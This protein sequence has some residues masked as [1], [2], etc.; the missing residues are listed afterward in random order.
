[1]DIIE[2]Q[3]SNLVKT[4]FPAFYQESGPLFIQFVTE[5]YKWMESATPARNEY[6]C[7]QKSM[8]AVKAKSANV[9]G[10]GTFFANQYSSG[11][12]I[13]ICKGEN[14]ND[15]EIFTV[16]R[17]SNNT[18]LTLKS[19]KLPTFSIPKTRHGTVSDKPNALYYARQF[20]EIKDIDE[21]LEEFIV[22]FKTKYLVGIQFDTKTDTRKFVKHSLDLYRSKGTERSIDLLFK[23]VFGKPA[24]VYYP[25]QD[26]FRL[27]SGEWYIP[28]Y[29]ELSLNEENINLKN[30]QIKG[31]TS[32]AT[33][34]VEEVVRRLVGDKFVDIA[35]ISAINGNFITFERV[36]VS[37]GSFYAN[38]E[39]TIVGSL[40]SIEVDVAG[41][42][43]NFQVNET[44]DITS[45]NGV[46]AKAKVLSTANSTGT[47]SFTL[48]DG[49][50][51]Y[52][53]TDQVFANLVGTVSITNNSTTVTGTSTKFDIDLSV[54]GH[55]AV[56]T[57]SSS[58]QTKR[59][60][61]IASN[62]SL[63]VNA[64]FSTT[65]AT[66]SY[67]A[68]N[69]APTVFVSDKVLTLSNVVIQ[70]TSPITEYFTLLESINQPLADINYTSASGLFEI[71]SNVYTYN[72]GTPDGF[73]RVLANDR[74]T[75]NS[76]T[77]TVSVIS[78][79][80]N[81]ASIYSTGNTVNATLAVSNGYY[82][83]SATAKI[84][85]RYSNVE[86]ICNSVS[87]TFSVNETV[88]QSES[89]AVGV[90][91]SISTL[92]SNNTSIALSN[93]YGVFK[94]GLSVYGNT[95]G[96]TANILNIQMDVGVIEISNSFITTTNN[97]VLFTNSG[98]SGT[99]TSLSL[100]SGANLT[101]SSTLTNTEVISLNTDKIKPYLTLNLNATSW[102]FPANTSANLSTIIAN[103]LTVSNSTIGKIEAI[104]SS[105]QGQDY[106]K[107][108]IVSVYESK[109]YPFSRPDTYYL[110]I[111]GATSDFEVG[112][113][114]TQSSSNARGL[115]KSGSNSTF[116]IIQNLRFNTNNSFVATAN[117]ASKIAGSDSGVT[118]NVT[119]VQ[120]L[121][122]GPIQG[123][124]FTSNGK[125]TISTGA[126]TSLEILDSGFGY[127]NGEIVTITSGNNTGSGF[128]VLNNYGTG[129]GFYRDRNGF[130]SDEKKL[131]DGFYWQ[132]YSYEIRSGVISDFTDMVK[133][134]VHVAGTKSFDALFYDTINS[135]NTNSNSV[136]TSALYEG[137]FPLG[138]YQETQISYLDKYC[139]PLSDYND[140]ISV[141]YDCEVS[142]PSYINTTIDLETDKQNIINVTYDCESYS[143]AIDLEKTLR[144]Y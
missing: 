42:G 57:N 129:T 66:A 7:E 65:N 118:A 29:L 120:A 83:R 119:T 96:A 110:N 95:S 47:L 48:N 12:K 59:I 26:L 38:T 113:V 61:S 70:N 43:S 114:I 107:F 144:R 30:K 123:F 49:G 23:I 18:F 130:L 102:P 121:S 1:M 92:S 103:A 55:I 76:G 62:T 37:D 137:F 73:G 64:K 31:V 9:V 68:I 99:I 89:G 13:A 8:I 78:G 71:G 87:G 86:L 39:T 135:T 44:V 63:T 34:F 15:Y 20:L 134:V 16:D 91:S 104:V 79:N 6:F 136:I 74:K 53:N 100:G 126:I 4:Q 32:G 131:S 108:P 140:P 75:T 139:Y 40:S 33:A 19:D 14:K 46:G 17:V 22:Y 41:T 143:E 50:Y 5:Y 24:E 109:T 54:G 84:M 85:G 56:Y 28:R 3:I 88:I 21:T 2:K 116:L 112:E 69:P 51:G 105:S 141:V 10:T 128:A 72:S 77:L 117:V 125:L 133:N 60:V 81:Y 106:N 97:H 82:D 11:D 132:E 52:S 101:I 36:V 80:L 124:N 115:V 94:S 25:G 111:V 122:V 93:A 127:V 142:Q 58:Y 35:Y 90:V 98:V 27:S 45:F 138:D 67:A